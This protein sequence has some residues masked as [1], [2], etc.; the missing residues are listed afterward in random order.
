MHNEVAFANYLD[1]Q[2]Q[3]QSFE[4]L[5]LYRW[6]SANLTGIDPPERIQ[7]FLV[8]ANY[9][10]ALGMKPIMGRN[11]SARRKSAGQRCRRHHHSQSLAK[12]FRRR[13]KHPQ[14][15]DHHQQHR[16]HGRRSDAG[17]FQLSQRRR[18][19]CA[20]GDD[21]G[22]DEEPRALIATTLSDDSNPASPSKA[23]KADIDN[24][25]ARLEQQYPETNTGWG[26][27]VFPIV[28]DTV[29]TYDT[30]LWVMMAAVGF[31]LLIACA[32]VANLMLA[33]ASGRQKEI[34]LRAALGASRW[35]IIRQ[36][37]TESVIVALIGGALGVL[38]GFL[39]Y[40]CIA[41]S[42]SRATRRSLRR[43]G[44]SSASTFTVLAFTLGLSLF[45]GIVFG[46]APA[47][48]VFE[49]QS[50]RFVERRKPANVRA[51][52]SA[53]KLARRF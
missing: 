8:T 42:E 12:T 22:D 17:T 28:A 6:W 2:A 29:R 36:L 1:W 33:R 23:R 15:D 5:A 30:A 19:L 34:A 18:S 45:S 41:C 11:F 49:T 39:G 37:L 48:Q 16:A 9:L 27:T 53:A 20:S 47:L 52:A 35:R 24:I 43:A 21:A 46:L 14:Q 3:N 7:G 40:R 44:I 51:V 26:A 31:V 25:T 38:V 32:N 13:S 50:Q 4:Q 10:D